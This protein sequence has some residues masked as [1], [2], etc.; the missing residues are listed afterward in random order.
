ME[1]VTTNKPDDFVLATNQT[2]SIRD[3]VNIC[4]KYLNIDIIW[5]GK[6][7]N[8][9]GINLLNNK[10]VIKVNPKYYRPAEVHFLKG[11][12][13]KAKKLLNWRPK[14]LVKDL[15]KLMINEDLK[16]LD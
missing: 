10:T 6:G 3:F 9:R 1:N 8:E 4:C 11:S 13:F 16:R 5:K 15:A 12:Y 2:C 14:V 7:L